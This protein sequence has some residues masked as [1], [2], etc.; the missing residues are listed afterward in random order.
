ME[1]DAESFPGECVG[2]LRAAARHGQDRELETPA[3]ALVL[4][5]LERI[6]SLEAE[7]RHL[8]AQISPPRR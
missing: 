4:R 7:L 1:A 5:L 2:R 8:H 3:V 6:A